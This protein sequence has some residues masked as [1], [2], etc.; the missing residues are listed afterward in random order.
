MQTNTE[1]GFVFDS[2]LFEFD[3][4]FECQF[5]VMVLDTAR[6]ISIPK[7]SFVLNASEIHLYPDPFWFPGTRLLESDLFSKSPAA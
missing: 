3:L 5:A 4:G 6:F 2:G 7:F 1:K